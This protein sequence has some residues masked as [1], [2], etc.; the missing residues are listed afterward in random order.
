MPRSTDRILTT[1]A[2]SLPRPDDVVD[3]IGM[4]VY[5]E[6]WDASTADPGKRFDYFLDQPFGL[7]WHRDFARQRGKQ[8]SYPEWGV[9]QFGDSPFFVQQMHD[10]FLQNDDRIA[11]AAYFDVDGQWP[12]QIDNNQFPQ[13]Q[14][15]FRK[16]FRR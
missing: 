15:L 5:A 9:G 1:H 2:G 8:I 16:L 4:D 10:W 14:K 11:Y 13:S 6:T 3:I 7:K 12:T